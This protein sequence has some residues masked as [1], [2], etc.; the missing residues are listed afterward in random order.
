MHRYVCRDGLLRREVVDCLAAAA[1]LPAASKPEA[2]AAPLPGSP[3]RDQPQAQAALGAATQSAAPAGTSGGCV[4]Q[5]AR[6]VA[7][8]EAPSQAVFMPSRRPVA[9]NVVL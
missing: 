9:W 1:P 8:P 5:N 7:E 6:A 3:V 4:T 2:A